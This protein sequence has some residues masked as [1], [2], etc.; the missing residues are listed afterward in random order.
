[1]LPDEV[2]F[3]QYVGCV[4]REEDLLDMRGFFDG[5]EDFLVVR[6]R[7]EAGGLGDDDWVAVFGSWSHDDNSALS[8]I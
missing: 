3:R 6:V 5:D 4:A 7:M 8:Q 1:M 2:L